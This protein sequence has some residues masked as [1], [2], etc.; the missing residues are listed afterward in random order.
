MIRM[1]HITKE[2]RKQIEEA[3]DQ[4]FANE[5][6]QLPK[7]V[8]LTE[9]QTKVLLDIAAQRAAS[10]KKMMLPKVSVTGAD[11]RHVDRVNRELDEYEM[12]RCKIQVHKKTRAKATAL[13][14][15]E[16]TRSAIVELLGHS[17]LLY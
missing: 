15:A 4:F 17:V 5:E 9:S 13:K 1:A 10:K 12:V 8:E 14:L 6:S 3:V 2:Q 16:R 7:Q 11:G